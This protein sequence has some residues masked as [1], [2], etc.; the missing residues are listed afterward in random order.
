MEE[1]VAFTG[2]IVVFCACGGEEEAHRIAEALIDRRLAACVTI[3]PKVQSVYRWK[4]AIEHSEEFLLIIKSSSD[5][6]ESLREE[7]ARLHSYEVPE[8]LAL[9]VVD[10]AASYLEWM[11][12]ELTPT[13]S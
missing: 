10:G 7:I 6:F 3:L 12:R 4:G 1:K 2:K 5:H 11:I 8:V 9:P 13:A